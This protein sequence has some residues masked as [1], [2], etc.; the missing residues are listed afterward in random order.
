LRIHII[1]I[2]ENRRGVKAVLK[3]QKPRGCGVSMGGRHGKPGFYQVG[4]LSIQT[5]V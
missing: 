4:A 3:T 1:K 2:G 5:G